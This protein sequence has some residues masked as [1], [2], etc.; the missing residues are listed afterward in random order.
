MRFKVKNTDLFLMPGNPHM[1][2]LAT[3]SYGLREFVAMVC[4]KGPKQGCCYIEEVVLNTVDFTTDVFANLKFIEDDE[5]AFDLAKF[6][7]DR[8][9][10]DIPKRIEEIMTFPAYASIRR[11]LSGE[12]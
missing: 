8:Q 2:H 6:L 7:E 1:L 4:L 5:L 10:L 3:V 9:V 12:T 11:Q